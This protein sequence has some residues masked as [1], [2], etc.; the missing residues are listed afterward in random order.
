M[1]RDVQC[2]HVTSCRDLTKMAKKRNMGPDSS[3]PLWTFTPQ[4]Y[5]AH[6]SDIYPIQIESKTL[7]PAVLGPG[8]LSFPPSTPV[9][10]QKKKS[11]SSRRYAFPYTFPIP[12]SLKQRKEKSKILLNKSSNFPQFGIGNGDIQNGWVE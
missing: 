12:H 11:G 6:N 2:I 4:T 1:V 5:R 3:S 9:V 7:L 8:I 10:C